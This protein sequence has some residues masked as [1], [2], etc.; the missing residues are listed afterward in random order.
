M[1]DLHSH[2]LPG[3]DDGA[4]NLDEAMS[5]VRSMAADGVRAVA[6]TP[7]VRDDWP[8]TP[9]EM[10]EAVAALRTEVE[11]AGVPLD[12]LRG[13]ELALDE[14]ARLDETERA[15]FGLGGN[16]QLLL[17]E[18]PYW[19]WP[20]GLAQTVRELAAAGIVSVIA[21][22]ERNGEVQERPD[23]LDEIVRAGAVV[24][25]TA[26]SVDGRLGRRVAA[27][28]RTLLD[29]RLAHLIASD[30]HAPAVREGGLSAA[31]CALG[32]KQLGR[33]LTEDVPLALIEGAPLPERPKSA[34]R[35][36]FRR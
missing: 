9:R 17:L 8:T 13:G 23:G 27:C 18:F 30:A 10:E 21:H 22:P 36:M 34:R 31:V 29:S 19:G 25:L 28:S 24:Q 32:D 16:P 20:L 35:R 15:R 11:T 26:A 3:L 12:V 5:I 6:A 14:L 7:H 1:I 4:R 2:L 33:W